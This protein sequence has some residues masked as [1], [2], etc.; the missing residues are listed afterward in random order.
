MKCYTDPQGIAV[1]SVSKDMP[2]QQC[3]VQYGDVILMFAVVN[4][5][6]VGYLIRCF[7]TNPSQFERALSDAAANDR[8]LILVIT[9][10]QVP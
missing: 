6:K 1:S 7:G 8:S 4:S 5:E 2:A 3:G 9:R 10:P